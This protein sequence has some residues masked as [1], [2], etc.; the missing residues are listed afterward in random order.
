MSVCKAEEVLWHPSGLPVQI[1]V[2]GEDEM[3]EVSA[4]RRHSMNRVECAF[5]GLC[6]A[7]WASFALVNRRG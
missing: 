1:L 6:S 7:E 2:A 5:A 4:V 3:A